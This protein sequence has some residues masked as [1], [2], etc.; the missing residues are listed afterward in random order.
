MHPN[1]GN[2]FTGELLRGKIMKNRS[3]FWQRKIIPQMRII[4]ALG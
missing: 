4:L 3:A 1:G 2:T